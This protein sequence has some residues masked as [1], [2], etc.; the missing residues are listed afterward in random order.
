MKL[1]VIGKMLANLPVEVVIG[2]T[3]IMGT[4]FKV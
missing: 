3:L 2:K 4:L 1:T